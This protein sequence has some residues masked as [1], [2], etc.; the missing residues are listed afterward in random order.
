[1]SLYINPD[2]VSS[3]LLSDGWHDI[4]PE[5][6]FLDAYEYVYPRNQHGDLQI[7]H[8][9]GNSGICATGFAF[10]ELDDE[11]VSGPLTAIEAV[12]YR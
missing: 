11:K 3:V 5:S 10:T 4:K 7:A 9:G 1:M 6:F 2:K 8:G 12:R